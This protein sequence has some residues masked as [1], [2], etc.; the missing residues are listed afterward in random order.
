V[1]KSGVRAGVPCRSPGHFPGCPSAAAVAAQINNGGSPGLTA[2]SKTSGSPREDTR[3]SSELGLYCRPGALTGRRFQRAV[4][5]PPAFS[6]TVPQ[7]SPA[8]GPP[9]PALRNRRH[10]QALPGQPGKGQTHLLLALGIEDLDAFKPSLLLTVVDL[11][12]VKDMPLHD[13]SSAASAAFH[14]GPVTVLLAILA[15]AM[16]FQMHAR[17]AL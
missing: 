14:D 6:A 1:G 13:P 4:N 8:S 10:A 5:W 11:A 2:Y 3:I 16:T 7:F 15:S 17:R 9:S 12:Q